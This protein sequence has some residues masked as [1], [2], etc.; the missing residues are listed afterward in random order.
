MLRAGIEPVDLLNAFAG[1]GAYTTTELAYGEHPRQRMSIYLP[2]DA[3]P[4]RSQP[5][6]FVYGGAWRDGDR[7]DYLFV[8][9]ALARAGFPVIVPDYRLFPAV[10]AP[11]FEQDVAAALHAAAA[12]W[13]ELTGAKLREVGLIGH[14]AGAYIGAAL[15]LQA[16]FI[17]DAVLPVPVY[18]F[19]GMA[20]PYVLPLD[21]DLVTGVYTG[22]S[23]EQ[24]DLTRFVSNAGAPVLL[25]HGSDDDIVSPR[26][27]RMLAAALAQ[28]DANA[29]LSEFD[30]MDHKK[31]VGSFS[32]PLSALYPVKSE[33]L[34]FL[35]DAA[36]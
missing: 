23:A 28:S 8:A 21:D 26:H 30:S 19:V 4:R 33:V 27:S 11:S 36:R 18:A 20:G 3:G 34:R 25:L 17:E 35:R 24:V 22:F 12:Q 16:D 7:E 13:P 29:S 14:S 1:R 15:F 5:V 10:T 9:A 6:C 2:P 31:L 32:W